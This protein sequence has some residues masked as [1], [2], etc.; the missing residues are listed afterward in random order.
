M[1]A[2]AKR[3]RK[4]ELVGLGS[5][6]PRVLSELGLDEVRRA[7]EIGERWEEAVGP[8][9]AR[10]AKPVAIRGEVLEVAVESSVWA[11]QLQLR[12]PEILASLGRVLEG[13]APTDLRFRVG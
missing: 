8:E 4:G 5:A 2:R 11:Q 13:S 10:H 6:L 1:R 9:I 7:F 3:R 12:R